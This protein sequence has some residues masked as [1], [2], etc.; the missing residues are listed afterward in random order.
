MLLN[1]SFPFAWF[2]LGAGLGSRLV[3]GSVSV[4]ENFFQ[5]PQLCITKLAF[6]IHWVFGLRQTDWDSQYLSWEEVYCGT[7]ALGGYSSHSGKFHY[8]QD[9]NLSLYMWHYLQGTLE[10]NTPGLVT[11]SIH[12]TSGQFCFHLS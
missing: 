5:S 12:F 8:I 4:L 9:V 3:D 6:V 10:I 7:I 1:T 11:P 2:S